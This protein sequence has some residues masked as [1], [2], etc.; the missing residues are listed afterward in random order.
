MS[1]MKGLENISQ[2]E[3]GHKKI[4]LRNEKGHQGRCSHCQE[5]MAGKFLFLH[6]VMSFIGFERKRLSRPK[7]FSER[8]SEQTHSSPLYVNKYNCLRQSIDAFYLIPD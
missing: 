3:I 6:K 7:P 2:K 8:H 4:S 1:S 5:M